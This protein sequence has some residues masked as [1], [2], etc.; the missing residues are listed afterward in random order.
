MV[1]S[2][3]RREWKGPDWRRKELEELLVPMAVADIPNV[4]VA[5]GNNVPPLPQAGSDTRM[6]DVHLEVAGTGNIGAAAVPFVLAAGAAGTVLVVA[7]RIAA[8]G[9]AVRGG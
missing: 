4:A 3:E 6:S 9:E 5:V 8:G 1:S 7:A 2:G